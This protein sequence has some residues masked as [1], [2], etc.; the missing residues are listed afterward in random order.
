MYGSFIHSKTHLF[1]IVKLSILFQLL[2]PT[3][4]RNTPAGSSL[5]QITHY[6]QLIKSNRFAM[7]DYGAIKNSIQYGS[8]CPPSYHLKSIRVPVNLVYSVNDLMA[9]VIDVQTLNDQLP[10]VVSLYQVKDELFTHFDFVWGLHAKEQVYDHV[11]AMMEN[12]SL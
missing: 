11:I 12:G 2:L 10:N 8:I 7:Y 1:L 6:G 3:I 4:L 9:D 5:R